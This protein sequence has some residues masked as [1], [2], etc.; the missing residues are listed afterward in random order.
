MTAQ[1]HIGMGYLVPLTRATDGIC[2]LYPALG[3]MH[4]AI[5]TYS[6]LL[7]DWTVDGDLFVPSLGYLKRS[8][9]KETLLRDLLLVIGMLLL[10]IGLNQAGLTPYGHFPADRPGIMLMAIEGLLG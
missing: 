10:I 8:A 9:Q 6:L 3:V 7:H 1:F 4:L 5:G 2:H